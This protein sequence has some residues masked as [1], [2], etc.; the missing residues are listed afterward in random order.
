VN[1]EGKYIDGTVTDDGRRLHQNHFDNIDPKRV[2]AKA[3]QSHEENPNKKLII[4][5]MQPHAPYI[6]DNADELRQELEENHGLKSKYFTKDLGEDYEQYGS[7]MGLAKKG[8]ISDGKL[9]VLY[10]ENLA[11]VLNEVKELISKLDGKTV[12]TSDH[13]ELLGE[14]DG[15]WQY[16][17]PEYVF[18]EELRKVP[19]LVVDS[20]NRRDINTNRPIDNEEISNQD[21]NEQLEL[22]GYN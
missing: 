15:P 22:L 14:S 8:K 1:S 9:R 16:G 18:N 12:V 2:T 13:G 7:L 3:L 10:I 11:V 17:H 5:Y 19:W 6:G 21:L 4:H 20:D